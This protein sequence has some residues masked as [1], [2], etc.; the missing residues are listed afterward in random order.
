M[1]RNPVRHFCVALVG[2]LSISGVLAL[3]AA[4]P[5]RAE[6]AEQTARARQLFRDCIKAGEEERWEQAAH[7]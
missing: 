6:D 2:Y 4:S 3:V 1:C 5:A 7:C